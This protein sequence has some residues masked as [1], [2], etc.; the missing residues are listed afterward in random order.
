MCKTKNVKLIL[1]FYWKTISKKPEGNKPFGRQGVDERMGSEWIL[2]IQAVGVWSG[3]S[4][5]RIGVGGG[6]F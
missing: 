3:S 4:W 6:L 5:P 2:G 1:N